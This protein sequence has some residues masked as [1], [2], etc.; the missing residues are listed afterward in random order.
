VSIT[1]RNGLPAH[2]RDDAVRLYWQAFGGKLGR[3]LG[4]DRLAFRLLEKVMRGDHAIVALSEDGALLG[5]VGFKSTDGAFA[6]GGL[7]DLRSVY[8]PIGSLWRAAL[9][10]LLERDLDNDRFLMDGICVA[11]TARGRGV[12]T[13]L[14]DAIC[15]EGRRRGYPSVRLDVIDA[16]PRAR[17]LYERQGFVPTRTSRIGLLRL[18]FGFSAAT[19]MVRKLV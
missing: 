3:V 6:G 14:L 7:A 9:L 18:V 5:L 16:N 8:G 4:P 11:D 17:A 12:G 10:W 19:T 2:L 1:I 15:V 13:A